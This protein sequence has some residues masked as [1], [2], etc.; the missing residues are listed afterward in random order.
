MQPRREPSRAQRIVPEVLQLFRDE[1]SRSL[2]T[3]G[4]NGDSFKISDTLRNGLTTL[5]PRQMVDLLAA[6]ASDDTICS[7]PT[8]V[9]SQLLAQFQPRTILASLRRLTAPA[10]APNTAKNRELV[11]ALMDHVAAN[12][13]EFATPSL[14]PDLLLMCLKTVRPE[15]RSFVAMTRQR[16]PQV[17]LIVEGLL[18]EVVTQARRGSA[19]SSGCGVR[20][21]DA[22]AIIGV[23]YF[24]AKMGLKAEANLPAAPEI[25]CLINEAARQVATNGV[26]ES[27]GREGVAKFLWTLA[28]LLPPIPLILNSRDAARVTGEGEGEGSDRISEEHL[29]DAFLVLGDRAEALMEELTAGEIATCLWSFSTLEMVHERL[30]RS[31]VEALG[32]RDLTTFT[33]MDMRF[34]LQA[35]SRTGTVLPPSVCQRLLAH[36]WATSQGPIAGSADHRAGTVLSLGKLLQG[37]DD[38]T[39]HQGDTSLRLGAAERMRF[40]NTILVLMPPPE[41]VKSKSTPFLAGALSAIASHMSLESFTS[42]SETVIPLADDDQ[43][44][45]IMEAQFC[46]MELDDAASRLAAHISASFHT[47]R[48]RELSQSL[49]S[50]TSYFVSRAKHLLN[51]PDAPEWRG[52]TTAAPSR[53]LLSLEGLENSID[54]IIST[55]ADQGPNLRTLLARQFNPDDL[56]DLLF[57]LGQLEKGRSYLRATESPWVAL[58]LS[59][60]EADGLDLPMDEGL[61]THL[62]QKGTLAVREAAVHAVRQQGLGAFDSVQLTYILWALAET[63]PDSITASLSASGERLES[64]RLINDICVGLL[65]G[66]D[67]TLQHFDE[68]SLSLLAHTLQRLSSV[69]ATSGLTSMV[70]MAVLQHVATRRPLAA[71]RARSIVVLGNAMGSL[72]QSFCQTRDGSLCNKR[73]VLGDL[74]GTWADAARQRVDEAAAIE[75]VHMTWALSQFFRHPLSAR[76]MG[77]DRDGD[78]ASLSYDSL[79]RL[80]QELMQS[81]IDRMGSFSPLQVSRMLELLGSLPVLPADASPSTRD[82]TGRLASELTNHLR[83][84]RMKLMPIQQVPAVLLGFSGLLKLVDHDAATVANLTDEAARLLLPPSSPAPATNVGD[85]GPLAA[86]PPSRLRQL[87]VSLSILP[88]G[89]V[90]ASLPQAIA[91]LLSS[92]H[93]RQRYTESEWQEMWSGISRASSSHVSVRT[94]K[95]GRGKAG[96]GEGERDSVDRDVVETDRKRDEVRAMLREIGDKVGGVD[97]AELDSISAAVSRLHAARMNE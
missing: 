89:P 22:A 5:S 33:G 12:M 9:Y 1:C 78:S 11:T 41:A 6:I 92:P 15:R 53:T 20:V 76:D 59:T 36:L 58:A 97:G 16:H 8:P 30:F 24:C 95:E 40:A 13:S 71:F 72:V 4:G 28:S 60:P 91:R 52:L 77:D 37:A 23:L 73:S 14:A 68:A 51:F 84:T 80:Q 26:V 61:H 21:W 50:L 27:F 31:A 19:S 10:S 49:K 83:S 63:L 56:H 47:M 39:Q 17:A 45:T 42:G 46:L 62:L 32:Q 90:S 25:R 2:N 38:A 43:P 81:F 34:I 66:G 57:A 67:P 44:P 35:F 55:M 29:T 85:T 74:V 82:F 75:L 54:R 69:L 87:A 3:S 88:V 93:V 48:R 65:E 96:E 64:L 18:R 70:L 94:R 86:L 79:Q 7:V